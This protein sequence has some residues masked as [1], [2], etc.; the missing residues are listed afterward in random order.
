MNR[1]HQP[2]RGLFQCAWLASLVALGCVGGEPGASEAALR[3]FGLVVPGAT[4]EERVWQTAPLG[5]DGLLDDDADVLDEL[6]YD[7]MHAEGAPD[8][9]VVMDGNMPVCVDTWEAIHIELEKVL[10]DPSP[11]PM[12]G[13]PVFD[14]LPE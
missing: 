9:G 7:L 14:R 11:D 5:C 12:R 10:G 1:V 13:S 2:W 4:I 3:D 6:G 8:L